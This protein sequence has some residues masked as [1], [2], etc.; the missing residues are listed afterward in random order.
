MLQEQIMNAKTAIHLNTAGKGIYTHRITS[1]DGS[2]NFAQSIVLA[3]LTHKISY[4]SKTF[5]VL[6]SIQLSLCDESKCS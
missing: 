1:K 6:C 4:A 3:P 5:E 2:K